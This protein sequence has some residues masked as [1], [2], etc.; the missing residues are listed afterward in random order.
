MQLRPKLANIT[1]VDE[2]THLAMTLRRTCWG[3]IDGPH[4]L[5]AEFTS[6]S[7]T[8]SSS[9]IAS[10]SEALELPRES[11]VLLDRAHAIASTTL[12]SEGARVVITL[13][14]RTTLPEFVRAASLRGPHDVHIVLPASMADAMSAA[15]S[16]ADRVAYRPRASDI[17]AW[18]S[19][20]AAN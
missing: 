8:S 20:S 19:A 15:M 3:A 6:S 9:S 2:Q 17:L 13:D 16:A 1:Y 12:V 4:E 5:D 14:A 7:S 18:L 10:A 11:F